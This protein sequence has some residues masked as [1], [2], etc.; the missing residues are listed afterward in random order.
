MLS[1][2]LRAKFDITALKNW[3]LL[4]KR[5]FP[6]RNEPTPYQVWVS[7]VLLQQTQASVVISYFNRWMELFPTIEA[8]ALAPLSQVIKAVE[9]IG[10]YSRVRHM[11]EAAQNIVS[12]HGG[13]LPETKELLEQIKGLGPYTI[14][15]ILSFA[16]H[17]KAAAIDG[18][19]M[20]VISRYFLIETPIERQA[21]KKEIEHQ[22]MLLLP[23]KEPW[24]LMEALIELG[25]CICKKHPQ[26]MLCP[27]KETCSAY[28]E[29]K[30]NLLPLKTK[31]TSVLFL[32]RFV[33][34]LEYNKELLL[35]KVP[36]GNVMA[37]LYEFPYFDAPFANHPLAKE[38]TF[39]RTLPM[40][41]QSFTRYRA[42]LYPTIWKTE[43]PFSMKEYTWTALSEIKNLPFS[44]G[45][46]R[47][48]EAYATSI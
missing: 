47:I 25:A 12:T 7:E 9:G 34:I 18:N 35:R 24:I 27:V 11:H 44:S 32:Q 8:L 22:V 6:W 13:N 39:V 26:C 41:K 15:A 48:W 5:E 33:G 4:K 30:T 2:N 1:S 20:R 17:Q 14:G 37:D 45:H 38:A 40:V 31:K 43:A 23:D 19:V 3:F 36:S 21:T 16:F 29:K 46:R 10:Y 28:R 42:E